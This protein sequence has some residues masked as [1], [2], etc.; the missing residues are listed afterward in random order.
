MRLH[1]L[2]SGF[3]AVALVAAACSGTPGAGDLATEAIPEPAP[4]TQ[5][6]PATGRDIPP[7]STPVE[8]EDS[9]GARIAIQ[10]IDATLLTVAPDG[11]DPLPLSPDDGAE[12]TQPTWSPDSSFVAWSVQEPD[13]SAALRTDRFDQSA[14]L[15][16][17]TS[18]P[19]QMLSW[20]PTSTDVAFIA[21][22]PRGRELSTISVGETFGN[23][24]LV[25]S[26]EPLWFRWGPDADE[27]L[28]H[29]D[30]FRL[31]RVALDGTTISI[32]TDPGRFQT[33]VWSTDNRALVF[34]DR[35]GS[36]DTLIS[37]G[38]LGQGRLPLGTYEG[39]L[40]VVPN[41][42]FN[43][44]AIAVTERPPA[45]A[46][47]ITASLQLD[48]E[49]VSVIPQDQLFIV[50]VYGGAPQQVDR[51]PITSM[52]WNTNGD[53]LAYLVQV[54]VGATPWFEWRFVSEAATTTSPLFRPTDEFMAQ[55]APFFDQLAA[56]IT[57]F[58]PDDLQFVFTGEL[59]SGESGVW[60][61]DVADPKDPTKIADG[62]VAVWSP[63]PAGGNAQVIV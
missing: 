8:P 7:P 10:T 37:T 30:N 40:R 16:A 20:S 55:Y 48:D 23:E 3:L 14:P 62:V 33:P 39:Y 47:I 59:L 21:E 19:P 41:P 35:D 54:T 11:S 13:G 58:S 38:D 34:A 2:C 31:D 5:P 36:T 6:T 44:M 56:D 53:T 43:R 42:D 17:T 46:S 63:G 1:R 61:L 57:F 9:V 32:E 28:V 22:G 12:H 49:P 45:Q 18:G 24:H 25:D 51:V 50:A 29:A 27:I 4:T 52:Y 26:G 15:N 60:V